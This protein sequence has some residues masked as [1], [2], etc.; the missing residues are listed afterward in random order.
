[1]ISSNKFIY[2]T[3]CVGI[4]GAIMYYFNYSSKKEN[5]SSSDTSYLSNDKENDERK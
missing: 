1:M 4:L 3:V 2:S 5:I